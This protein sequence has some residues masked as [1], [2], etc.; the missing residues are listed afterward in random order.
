MSSQLFVNPYNFIPFGSTIE[1]RRR[2]RENLYRGQNRLIS[3]WLETELDTK[4]PLIIPDG[5]HPEY[6]DTD[7][8][9]YV[10]DPDEDQ[11]KKLHTEYKF[12]RI[13]GEDGE[14][15]RPAIPGSELR[16]MLRS[17]YETVTDSCVAF[18][19]DDKPISQRV[20]AFGS[21]R[22]RGLL[23]YE[24]TISGSGI[25][26]WV[27]YSTYAERKE[28]ESDGGRLKYKDGR[29]VTEKNGDYIENH[30]WLQYN[31]PVNPK[32]K[33][34]I[35]YLRENEKIYTWDFIGEDGKPDEIKN[36]EPYRALKSALQDRPK[37]LKN[38]NEVPNRN[39]QNALERA[40]QGKDNKIPVYYF[41]VKR[42]D[43]T[44]VYLSNSSIGRIAQRRRW[45]E[46]MGAHAPCDNTDRLCPACLL[47]GTVRDRGLK[48]HI[49]V[50][51][52]E[53]VGEIPL[54][55]HTLP[56]LG[57]P[58]TSAF[59]F[60]L[61]RSEGKQATYWN[62]DFYGEKVRD[63]NGKSHTE[64]HDLEEAAPRGRKRYWHSPPAADASKSRMNSTVEA[65]NGTF[66]F[67][68]YFDE[69]TEEQL[70]DLIW[71]ITL[72]DNRKE[73]TKQ[74]K[75]GHAKPLGYGSVKITVKEKVI[76]DIS[77]Q[78]DSI[79]IKMDTTEYK[80][81]IPEPGKNLDPEAVRTLLIMSDTQTIPENIPVEYPTDLDKQNIFTWFANNRTNPDRLKTL[82]E[83]GDKELTLR[84]NENA[85]KSKNSNKRGNA[86]HRQPASTTER[87]SG[88][89]KFYDMDRNFGY[90]AGEDGTDYR[91]SINS[92][93]RRYNPDISPEDL[94]KGCAVTFEP[95]NLHGKWTANQC[96]LEW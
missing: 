5:A 86:R 59:E 30:G 68:V 36:E 77:A 43:E 48:G 23:A 55:T 91:I 4:T 16:G 46:I 41:M 66:K 44:L 69:V 75:L 54:E 72:G 2:S 10:Q 93:N 47:F 64:Y 12:F 56:I 29:A 33:Y 67:R 58:R 25:R 76:R 31:I 85:S 9:R 26:R 19:L 1:E 90:I 18:L 83:P 11:K 95:V 8:K 27:L 87:I 35:A 24:E 73:S 88:K 39:L 42:G 53:P 57:E 78:E 62:F 6:W 20:P 94:K 79:E 7:N 37:G 51:D 38:R 81:I 74:H 96:R 28:V 40:K 80:D 60:Y 52:A 21:L 34:S 65:A 61:K 17:V 45:K 89:V 13:P 92:N 82:P 49:R 70:Q 84:K 22:K 71:V 15:E 50:T 32:G 3:G 14:E 63:P